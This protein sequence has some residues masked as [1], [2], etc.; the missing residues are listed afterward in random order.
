MCRSAQ[1]Q[2]SIRT[3]N[4]EKSLR[5]PGGRVRVARPK[6]VQAQNHPPPTYTRVCVCVCVWRY[7]GPVSPAPP[8]A[9]GRGEAV[10]PPP[11]PT[12]PAAVGPF[13]QHDPPP[14]GPS[15]RGMRSS[16]RGSAE[17]GSC[18]GKNDAGWVK[19]ACSRSSFVAHAK[20]GAS[21]LRGYP[22]PRCPGPRRPARRLRSLRRSPG[23][24]ERPRVVA[25]RCPS[26]PGLRRRRR[27]APGSGRAGGARGRGS[28]RFGTPLGERAKSATAGPGGTGQKGG[29]ADTGSPAGSVTPPAARPPAPRRRAPVF[30][31]AETAAAA[32]RGTGSETALA[33][34]TAG[35]A[36]LPRR[37]P[38]GGEQGGW[39]NGAQSRGGG[40]AD[41]RLFMR[42]CKK[43]NPQ[44]QVRP[45]S[46]TAPIYCRNRGR[47]SPR[48]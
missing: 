46:F 29:R 14:P 5:R 38:G 16:V 9:G 36:G 35:P 15:P 34:A 33:A 4:C 27:P 41:T 1:R 19:T 13:A 7:A 30:W 45:D 10:T 43:K 25:G 2:L 24:G 40:G 37:P 17:C 32:P 28:T 39:L 22:R 6:P 8:A 11:P 44:P 18:R 26:P 21:G 3:G 47:S 23:A 12:A 20:S 31:R 48:E 42:V